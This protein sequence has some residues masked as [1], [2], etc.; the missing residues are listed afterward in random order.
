MTQLKGGTRTESEDGTSRVDGVVSRVTIVCSSVCVY[1]CCCVLCI[2][3]CFSFLFLS[4]P[5]VALLCVAPLA[6]SRPPPRH[7][8]CAAHTTQHTTQQKAKQTNTICQ[9]NKQTTSG[10]KEIVRG[11]ISWYVTDQCSKRQ[12]ACNFSKESYQSELPRE[13]D[14]NSALIK[15]VNPHLQEDMRFLE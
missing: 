5:F 4:F 7:S 3:V 6:D 13:F 2:L 12:N 15:F 8:D 14:C 11:R 9:T 10:R 1:V